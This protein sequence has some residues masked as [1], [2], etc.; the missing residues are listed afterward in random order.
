VD[1]D[2][3]V[4]PPIWPTCCESNRSKDRGRIGHQTKREAKRRAVM[5]IAA[6]FLGLIGAIVVVT[7]L[8][9]IP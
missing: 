6:T 3:L 2:R 8:N 5:M 4:Q 9:R 7:F 1:P